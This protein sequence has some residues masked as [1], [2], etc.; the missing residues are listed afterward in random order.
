MEA[1]LA[2]VVLD[3]ESR[4]EDGLGRAFSIIEDRFGETVR[5]ADPSDW[6][7]DDPKTALQERAVLMGFDAPVYE[8]LEKSGPDHAPVFFCRVRVGESETDAKGSSMKRAQTEAARLL[9]R[10]F[11]SAQTHGFLK[12]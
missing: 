7:R 12:K 4:G 9:L 11:S 6:E 1:L 3:V 8:L 5:A 10:R 2:A